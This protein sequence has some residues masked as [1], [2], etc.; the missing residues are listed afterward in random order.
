MYLKTIIL[1]IGR[2]PEHAYRFRYAV[3]LARRHDAHL[4]IA[5][6]TQ[7]AGMPA[8]ITGRG[9]SAAYMAEAAE[10]GREHAAEVK[11]ELT[12]GCAAAGISWNWEVVEGDHNHILAER[13]L[14]ADVVV[15]SQDHGVEFHDHV[16]LQNPS[17]LIVMSACP[18]LVLPKQ[19]SRTAEI[20][21]VLIAWRDDPAAA[22]AVRG[23]RGALEKAE[24]V[25]LLS[26]GRTTHQPDKV[27]VEDV[28]AYLDR[29]G[30]KTESLSE[31]K[32]GSIADALLHRAEELEVDLMVMGAY[33]H[34]RWRELLL[35][36]ITSSVLRHQTVPV[37]LSH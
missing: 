8:A 6:L 14:L 16:G 19:C 15:V 12:A 24:K 37:L 2:D 33:S 5:Y 31:E 35:G 29:Q 34:T 26:V 32:S 13:S 10:L 36:G 25:Y 18:V 30:V 11:E 7:P 17:E 28:A 3:D 1:H 9:A 23:S 4:E 21:T 20:R 27:G 22:R